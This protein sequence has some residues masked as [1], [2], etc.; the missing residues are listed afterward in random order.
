[1]GDQKKEGIEVD[2]RRRRLLP[3]RWRRGY[4]CRRRGNEA[5]E[6][7]PRGK[8]KKERRARGREKAKR[9]RLCRSRG[10]FSYYSSV[11]RRIGC[12]LPLS[13]PLSSPSLCGSR[14]T[15][16]DTLMRKVRPPSLPLRPPTTPPHRSRF[17]RRPPRFDDCLNGIRG[18]RKERAPCLPFGGSGGD[19]RGGLWSKV[20]S[21]G[22]SGIAVVVVDIAH[23]FKLYYCAAAATHVASLARVAHGGKR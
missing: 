8:R 5:G 1:M 7:A 10:N 16:G 9:G 14:G 23:I 22:G 18:R 6:R 15:R 11:I 4:G 2:H 19:W 20:R 3:L 17:R 21:E 13:V 12:L